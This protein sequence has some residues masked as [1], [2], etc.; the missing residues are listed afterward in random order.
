MAIE[1][2]GIQLH[3]VHQIE[4]LEQ[5][6]FVYHS[7]PGMQGSVAQ[8]LGRDSV[9]LRVRGIFYGA[10]ATQDLEALR[11]VYKERQPVD[12][13]AEV[14][15]QAYFSQ[16]VLERF[17]VTQ[18]ADEP[19]QFSYALTIAEF[20]APTAAPVTTAQVDAAIQ[21][22]AASFM[23]VAMLPDALQIGAIPEVTNPIE[24]L[25][26]AIAPIQAAVQ[27]VDAATA[28]LKALFNL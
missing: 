1:L 24:P 2:A 25:R 3:R 5:S 18:A 13:L 28:G 11:R 7:I 8:D 19:E 6:N 20:V 14:V 21:L 17:E 22:E 15:G 27:S 4:T 16:V 12:F 26:G 10:K 9:R 23:T